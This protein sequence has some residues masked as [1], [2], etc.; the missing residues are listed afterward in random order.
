MACNSYISRSTQENCSTARLLVVR[1]DNSYSMKVRG[2]PCPCHVGL[3]MQSVPYYA[4]IYMQS[5]YE[6]WESVL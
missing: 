3:Y 2:R 1:F 5:V 4:V 6:G